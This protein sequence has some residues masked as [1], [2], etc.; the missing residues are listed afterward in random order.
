MSLT[1]EPRHALALLATGRNGTTRSL[2]TAHGFG[3][4]MIAGPL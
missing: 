2:L 4:A 3:V 1:A